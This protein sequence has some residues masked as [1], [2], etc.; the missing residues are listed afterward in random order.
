M[1]E[2]N[3]AVQGNGRYCDCGQHEGVGDL[4]PAD[5]AARY[6]RMAEKLGEYMT[7]DNRQYLKTWEFRHGA[8]SYSM[9]QIGTANGDKEGFMPKGAAVYAPR[10]IGSYAE[11]LTRRTGGGHWA[12]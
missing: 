5:R 3:F 2:R 7:E 8:V 9:V 1:N 12:D 10:I 11:L 6:K 4:S